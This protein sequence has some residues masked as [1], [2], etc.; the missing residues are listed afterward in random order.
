MRADKGCTGTP[1]AR[2][3]GRAVSSERC[4]VDVYTCSGAYADS[5]A[6]RTVATECGKSLSLPLLVSLSHPETASAA[7]SPCSARASLARR[8]ARATNR[9]TVRASQSAYAD[10]LELIRMCCETSCDKRRGR[11]PLSCESPTIKPPV[12]GFLPGC[13]LTI[14][15]AC[16]RG[17]K[18][19]C[20]LA[21]CDG[22]ETARALSGS[23]GV[24]GTGEKGWGSDP[25]RVTLGESSRASV[26]CLRHAMP[27]LPR[28]CRGL[29]AAA[30]ACGGGG[31][32]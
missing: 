15:S 2:A 26:S 23:G 11:T 13:R 20:M 32:I 16:H 3:S 17:A 6:A 27:L 21:A 10:P 30:A 7:S 12:L 29:N 9:G 19:A 5:L 25:S 4:R 1:I 28:S 18:M 22:A 31:G 8:E 24:R 14:S